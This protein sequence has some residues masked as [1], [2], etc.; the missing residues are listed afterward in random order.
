LRANGWTLLREL[1]AAGGLAAVR[2]EEHGDARAADWWYLDQELSAQRTKRVQRTLATVAAVVG[3][4][5]LLYFA[6]T[7]LFPVDPNVQGATSAVISGQ[8]NALDGDMEAA[9]R[10]SGSHPLQARRP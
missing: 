9:L 5:L 3:A 1:E 10:T 7:T 2:R 6:F 8:Q 4:V